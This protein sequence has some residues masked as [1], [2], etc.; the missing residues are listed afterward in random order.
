MSKTRKLSIRSAVPDSE[1]YEV[2]ELIHTE[3][4][5]S[6]VCRSDSSGSPY[7]AYT[8]QAIALGWE[9]TVVFGRPERLGRSPPMVSAEKPSSLWKL[10]IPAS[11]RSGLSR[12]PNRRD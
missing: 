3:T 9:V 10:V 6:T 12:S 7:R 2:Y 11:Q 1:V 8:V 4:T 5:D